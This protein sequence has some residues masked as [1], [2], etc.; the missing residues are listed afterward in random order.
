MSN[1]HELSVTFDDLFGNDPD[2]LRLERLDAILEKVV[3][4]TFRKERINPDELIRVVDQGKVI[5]MTAEEADKILKQEPQDLQEN[6]QQALRGDFKMIAQELQILFLLSQHT[7]KSYA[8]QS[9]IPANEIQRSQ[10]QLLR[11]GRQIVTLLD[12]LRESEHYIRKTRKENPILCQFEER[13]AAFL[14]AQREGAQDEA[15]VLAQE[16]AKIKARYVR[17]SQGLVQVTHQSQKLRLDIQHHKKSLLSLQKYLMAQREGVLQDNIRD[18]RKT[19]E[20]LQGAL[21]RT[22][23]EKRKQYQDA[24][25][26]REAIVHQ[27][28]K[29]LQAVQKEFSILEK[30]EN[31]TEQLIV[32]LE[33]HLHKKEPPPE[34][35]SKPSKSPEAK[36]PASPS[37]SKE[38]AQ[39]KRM[40]SAQR[41]EKN[42]SN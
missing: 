17:I 35:E 26:E 42:N 31:E 14:K 25:Q 11:L 3:F 7:L 12:Q 8:E 9:L 13:M 33:D 20:S 16:L 41:R 32:G 39:S 18:M 27:N 21:K 23:E 1:K 34:K 15:M 40:V 6:I 36:T 5:W 24:L 28:N 22:Q 19:I 29:E 10:P 4:E 38:N 2:N 30:K 37:D